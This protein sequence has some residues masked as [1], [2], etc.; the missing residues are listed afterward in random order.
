MLVCAD[1]DSLSR[2]HAGLPMYLKTPSTPFAHLS[3][4]R[5]LAEQPLLLNRTRGKLQR[6]AEVPMLGIVPTMRTPP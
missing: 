1:R 2:D 4:F 6:A 5:S 3:L